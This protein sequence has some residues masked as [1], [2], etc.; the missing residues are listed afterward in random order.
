MGWE[1]LAQ[2]CCFWLL[3]P[4]PVAP[5]P[6]ALSLPH[7]DLQWAST[8]LTNSGLWG[9]QV[10]LSPPGA[11][12]CALWVKGCG[13]LKLYRFLASEWTC[14]MGICFGSFVFVF[15]WDSALWKFL[16]FPLT[17]NRREKWL[18][19]F[20]LQQNNLYSVLSSASSVWNHS[21]L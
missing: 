4:E 14:S 8:T 2:Q 6:W 11:C 12:L 21:V 15:W 5:P 16:S 19:T 9:A 13:S 20:I 3:R 1:A 18:D 17:E 7:P 10:A